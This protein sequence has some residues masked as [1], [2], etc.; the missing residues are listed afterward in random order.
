MMY[1]LY[2]AI[3]IGDQIQEH[4]WKTFLRFEE[5]WEVAQA[6]THNRPAISARCVRVELKNDERKP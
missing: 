3:L 2:V 4:Q 1:A 5:C 6:V